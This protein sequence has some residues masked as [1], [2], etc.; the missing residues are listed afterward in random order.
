MTEEE[1]KSLK[2]EM[3]ELR[4]RCKLEVDRITKQKDEEMDKVHNRYFLLWLIVICII[5]CFINKLALS[6]PTCSVKQALARKEETL[7]SLRSQHQVCL[8]LD[9]VNE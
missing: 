8:R 4:A 9:N 6:F 2:L 5:D 1:N 7:N 3:N